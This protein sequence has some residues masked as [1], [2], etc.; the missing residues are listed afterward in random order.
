MDRLE[1]SLS[2]QKIAYLQGLVKGSAK[3]FIEPF[4][5][6]GNHFEE[7]IVEQKRR[8]GR[9]TVIFGTMIQHLI[10][11][12]LLVPNRPDA[13]INFS[14]FIKMTIRV[15]EAHDFNADLYSTT[16]LK[17]ATDKLPFSGAV[18]RQQFLVK[19]K[20]KQPNL[21]TLSDWLQPKVEA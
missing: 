4:E 18:K 12:L 5:C 8:F 1:Q 17:H 11:H 14:S 19:E 20:I 16:N 21:S 2:I 13:S 10:Q 15:F 6:D 7:A 9:P 3:E